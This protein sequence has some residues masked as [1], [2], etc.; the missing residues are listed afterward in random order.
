MKKPVQDMKVKMESLKQT[1]TGVKL[2]LKNLEVK[3]KPE[4]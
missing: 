1:Q 4:R 3:Q 2:E